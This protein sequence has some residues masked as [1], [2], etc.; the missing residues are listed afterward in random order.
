MAIEQEKSN[1]LRPLFSSTVT[2]STL[3][4]TSGLVK[5]HT[6]LFFFSVGGNIHQ[7]KQLCN[8][9]SMGSRSIWLI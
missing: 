3:G 9:Y 8:V 7:F 6:Y 1:V 4:T 2:Y 5:E